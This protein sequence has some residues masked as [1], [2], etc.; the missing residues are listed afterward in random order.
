MKKFA[1]LL[2]AVAALTALA[3]CKKEVTRVE[4]LDQAYGIVVDIMPEDWITDDDGLSYRTSFDVPE[5]DDNIFDH[6][7]VI[8]YLS[9][10]DG[11]YEA[12]PEVYD[13]ISYGALHGTGAITVDLHAVDGSK[14]SPPGVEVFG[15]VVL[16]D[17]RALK[18]HPDVNLQDYDAVR[19][20]FRL[21]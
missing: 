17:A 1:F 2:V 18:A 14:I 21:R 6:G 15:K 3:S 9:F 7:A 12:L 13:G 4:R 16:I 11:Q 8:V 20:V 19:S 10:Q 5:L